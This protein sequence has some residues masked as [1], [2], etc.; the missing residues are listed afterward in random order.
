MPLLLSALSVISYPRFSPR[1]GLLPAAADPADPVNNTCRRP[2]F[3]A[4]HQSNTFL[5]Q[6]A[7]NLFIAVSCGAIPPNR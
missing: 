4:N 1:C 2:P 3:A 5:S 6:I 7:K